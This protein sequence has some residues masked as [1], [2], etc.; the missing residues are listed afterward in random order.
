M[1]YAILAVYLPLWQSWP[2]ILAAYMSYMTKCPIMTDTVTPEC[3]YID[4]VQNVSI[5]TSV[6]SG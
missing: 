5:L 2:A 4:I 3:M 6:L 1:S